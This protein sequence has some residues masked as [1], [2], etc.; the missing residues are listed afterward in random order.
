[1]DV[2]KT[3]T[4]GKH[5]NNIRE[6]PHLFDQEEQFTHEWHSYRHNP[7]FETLHQIVAHA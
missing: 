4:K 1:M 5:V 7:I 2:I 6:V 3:E